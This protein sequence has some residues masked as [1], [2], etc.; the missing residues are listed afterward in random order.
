MIRSM[1]AVVATVTLAVAPL[2][3][4]PVAK[5]A[6]NRDWSHSFAVTPDGGF[7]MGN[8]A[9]KVAI[10]E[11]GSLTCSHCRHFAEDAVKPLVGQYVRTG[12]ANYEYRSL[13]L[14]SVDIAAT[15]LARCGGPSH[16]FPIAE[17]L[18][19][20]QPTWLGKLTDD[21]LQKLG[22]QSQGD[23]MLAIARATGLIRI[24]SAHGIAP[25][26]AE[27]CLKSE[28]AAEQLAKM[29]QAASD[30]GVD[31]TPTFFVNGQRVPAYDWAT[32]EPYLKKAGG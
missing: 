22:G 17:Q 30:R 15:L 8:P 25:A 7:R 21:Q 23:M 11:Y 6:A 31:G 2:A 1:V 20:T 16:F 14:N 5:A 3:A 27:V 19:A 32:L 10:V 29:A 4:K 28:P 9:A 13:I 26:K 18:Y 12:K 24:A